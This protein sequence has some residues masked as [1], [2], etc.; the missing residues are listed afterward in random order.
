MTRHTIEPCPLAEAATGPADIVQGEKQLVLV[1][2]AELRQ[3]LAIAT[4]A[5]EIAAER[6]RQ[7]EGEGW[8]PQRDDLHATGQMARAAACYA[9]S[10]GRL[11]DYER[12]SPA[13]LPF[14]HLWPWCW[15]WWKPKDRRADLIRA[16]ALIVAE[17]ERLDRKQAR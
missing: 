17:I 15:T 8:T 2:Q 11:E 14:N 16:G 10:G 7:I 5:A 6:R 4:V 12:V 13:L 9:L 3:V 1:D